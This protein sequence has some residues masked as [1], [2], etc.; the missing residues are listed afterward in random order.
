VSLIDATLS[1]IATRSWSVNGD[2]LTGTAV[3]AYYRSIAAGEPNW[4]LLGAVSGTDRLT[5]RANQVLKAAKLIRYQ[6]GK[7]VTT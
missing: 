2:T 1:T 6:A 5:D 4:R 3:V 7:W